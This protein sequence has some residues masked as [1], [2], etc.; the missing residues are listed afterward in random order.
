MSVSYD[1]L[2]RTLLRV[3]GL[4]DPQSRCASVAFRIDSMRI[5]NIEHNNQTAIGVSRGGTPF[6]NF[7]RALQMYELSSHGAALPEAHHIQE[8]LDTCR[9]DVALF[10]R[11]LDF[12]ESHRL[13]D[14]TA[15]PGSIRFCAPFRRPGQIVALGRNY[16]VH[17]DKGSPTPPREPIIFCKSNTSVIGPEETVLLP[18]NLGRVE[19]EIELAVVIRKRAW[20]V[21][22]ADAADYIAGY[23]I[24]NDVSA[25]E[26][27]DSDFKQHY[28]LFRCKSLPTFT[29]MGPWV[30]T[31]DEIGTSP[32]L[33]MTLQVNG[34]TRVNSSTSG[35]IFGIPTLIEYVSGFLALEPGDIITTGCPSAGGAILPGNDL[36]LEIEGIGVLHNPVDA[37]QQYCPKSAESVAP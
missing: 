14:Q 11:V 22:A 36:R 33:R 5:A 21:T 7:T 15:L 4:K 32:A 17:S 25:Q 34:Q 24:L 27:H 35:L 1:R 18:P 13:E 10:G 8:L 6:V 12:I 29:P 31:T 37:S 3:E 26:L 30:V 28:P 19:P 16:P 2:I 23:T 9:F 20:G